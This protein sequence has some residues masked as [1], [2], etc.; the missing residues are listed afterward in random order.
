ML[1]KKND[2]NEENF[3][4]FEV[5][6]DAK[7]FDAAVGKAFNKNKG[8]I[9]IP[10]FRRGKAPRQIVEGM[11]GAGVFYEDALDDLAPQAF[12]FGISEG[13]IK[14][15]GRPSIENVNVNEDKSASFT[16][17]VRNYPVVTL[18]E[19]KGLKAPKAKVEISEDD[20]TAEVDKIRKRNAR[21][22]IST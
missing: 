13:K 3:T 22:V 7:E 9:N 8:Q 10:G 12:D 14:F 17:K 15:I 20:I 1:L 4:V 6:A 11:Y 19:Y 21:K 2:V 5:E 16:F 18:G